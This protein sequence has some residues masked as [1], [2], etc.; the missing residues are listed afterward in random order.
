MFFFYQLIVSIILLFSPIIILYRIFKGKEHKKRFLEKFSFPTKK[1]RKGNLIW[2]HGAS[3]GELMSIIP[4]IKYYEKKRFIDQILITSSTL[5]SSKIIDKYKFKKTCHQF[6]PIDQFIFT[7]KFLNFW[8]P[9]LAIY[10]DSE[11]WP[12]MFKNLNDTKIPLILLNARITRKTFKRWMKVKNFAKSVFDSIKIAYPQ[13]N[14]TKVFLKKLKIKN[15]NYLGNLKF[16]ENPDDNFNDFKNKINSKINKKKVWIA[17]STHKNEEIFCAKVHIK[18]KKKIKNLLTII[19]PRHIHRVEKIVY[20]INKLNLKTV[21]HSQNPQNFDDVDVYIVDT[22]GD[23]KTFHKIGSS[24]FLGG[25][26]I[27]HGGQNPLE[28]ARFGAKIFHGPN[29]DNFKDVYKL[30][31]SLNISKKITSTK[32]LASSIFFKKNNSSGNKIKN[33]GEKILKKTIKEINTQFYNEFK[34]T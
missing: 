24:V 27:K 5:S 15:L 17:S 26:L 34:K 22:F 7:K 19:I 11:I 25:S 30:L 3:V 2:F 32:Q 4:L 33:I 21:C 13:N 6:Y 31:R 23:T 14:E 20:E 29:I 9:N 28:A 10:V 8:K 16:A 12:G 1:R 18:L